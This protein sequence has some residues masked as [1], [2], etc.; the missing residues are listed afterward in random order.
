MD[1]NT[2]IKMAFQNVKKDIMEIKDQLLTIA[3]RQEKLE[4]SF[5][6]VKKKD[7]ELVQIR[8]SKKSNTEK[9]A[10]KK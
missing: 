6:E 9:K 10:S 1:S 3:E 2:S 8:S 7:H 4:A 5:E